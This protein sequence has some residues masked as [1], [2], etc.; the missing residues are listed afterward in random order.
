MSYNRDSRSSREVSIVSVGETSVKEASSDI[1]FMGYDRNQLPPT[2]LTAVNRF[3]AEG[4]G[5]EKV[6]QTDFLL[7]FDSVTFG[8][9]HNLWCTD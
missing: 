9:F 4:G 3:F 7:S 6:P 1:K 8:D 2:W 5:A